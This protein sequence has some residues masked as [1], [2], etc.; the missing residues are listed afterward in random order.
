M[1]LYRYLNS[2]PGLRWMF[3]IASGGKARTPD[4]KT[5]GII[6]KQGA[7]FT[8]GKSWI[9]KLQNRRRGSSASH[10]DSEATLFREVSLLLSS[11]TAAQGEIHLDGGLYFHRFAVQDVRP[12]TPLAHGFDRRL[13]KHWRPANGAQVLD[14][15]ALADRSLQNHLSLNACCFGDSRIYRI[16]SRYLVAGNYAGRN[17][18][19]LRRCDL[20]R[21]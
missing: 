17:A 3:P 6:R 21:R 2:T 12:V 16:G 1:K 4:P 9:Q 8:D 19:T 7:R 14:S 20:R 5:F 15:S 18:N 10:F 11:L 13:I